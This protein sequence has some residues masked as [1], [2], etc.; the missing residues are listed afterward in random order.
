M[1]ILNKNF[2]LKAYNIKIAIL[3]F[4]SPLSLIGLRIYVGL[5][6][7]K[8]G[9]TKLFNIDN[10]I[11]LFR[12]EYQTADKIKIFGHKF[13]TPEICAYSGTFVET[14]FSTLLILGLAGRFSALA[15]LVMTAVIQFTYDQSPEHIVWAL[16]LGTILLMGPGRGSWDY[17]IKSTFY[18]APDNDTIA[19]RLFATFCTLC[20]TLFVGFLIYKDILLNH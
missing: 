14:V 9:L 6:F 7:W 19:D 10:A 16:M 3:D 17:F 4:L 11:D 13:L 8:S 5:V 18:G 1:R 15:L 20:V 12:D 2:L